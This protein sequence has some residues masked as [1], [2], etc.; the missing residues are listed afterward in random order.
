[1]SFIDDNQYL[2]AWLTYFFAAVGCCL[3]WWKVTSFIKNA[4]W[5]DLLRGVALV[6]LFTPWYAGESPEFYAPAIVVLLMDLLL[7]GAKSGMK[8]GV[9]LLFALFAMLLILTIRQL[10]RHR[11]R[12]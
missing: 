6:V 3:F 10:R 8:G 9:A 5:R 7:E 1:M 2:L 12:S 4:G 11:S